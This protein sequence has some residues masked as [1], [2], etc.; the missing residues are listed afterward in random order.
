MLFTS[1]A[2]YA[3]SRFRCRRT[4]LQS[5]LLIQ[6]F[7]NL[8]AIVAIFLL[9]RQIGD[10]IPSLGL[11]T[12][13]GLILVYLGGVLGFNT[14]LMKGFFDAIPR[15]LDES[16]YIDGASPWTSYWYVIFPLVRP[17]LAV[18]GILTFIGTY[19]DFIMASVLLRSADIFTLGVGLTLLIG[20]QHGE[21][22]GEFAAGALIGALPIV[23]IMLLP[24]DYIVGGLTRGAVKVY[25][26]PP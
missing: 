9:V 26:D 22:W 4:M 20:Q 11:N 16:A 25:R 18:V 3:F 24:Q 1:L 23:I 17:I 6:V 19:G 13:G 15:D 7:P 21:K 5:I 8:L 14:W 10:H 2:A 12:H